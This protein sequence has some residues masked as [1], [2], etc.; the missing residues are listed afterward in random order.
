MK[1]RSLIPLIITFLVLLLFNACV[2]QKSAWKGTIEEVDGVTVIKNPKEPMYEEDVFQLEQ[3]LRIG[4]SQGK[5]EYMFSQIR[6]M[7]V[8]KERIYVLDS[9]EAH[10]KVFDKDGEYLRTIARKGQGP[11]ELEWPMQ[12]QI[13]SHQ[14]I[15]VHDLSVLSLSFFSLSGEFL[16]KMPLSKMPMPALLIMDSNSDLI[17]QFTIMEQRPKGAL[18]KFTSNKEKAFTLAEVDPYQTDAYNLIKPTL[19]FDVSKEDNIIWAVSTR[20]EIRITNPEGNLLKKITKD[21]IPVKITEEDKKEIYLK[22]FKRETIPPG[23]KA[24]LP[25]YFHPIGNIHIDDEG[26]I[27][28]RTPQKSKNGF[29]YYDVFDSE[30]KYMAK[31]TLKAIPETPLVWENNKMYAIEE[32]EDGY[33]YIKRYKV[34]WNY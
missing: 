12:I 15:M 16:R 11:G 14:E 9:K 1:I 26:R 27:Y 4:K 3:E 18:I 13:T 6:D 34:T 22:I 2:Q 24:E 20:Y 19:P 5:K 30:G 28:V 32:D 10:I 8:Y 33:Q 21:Y 29:Y 17:G 31:V 23:K 25:K 7:A